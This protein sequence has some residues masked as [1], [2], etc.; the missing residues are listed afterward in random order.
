[1]CK[2][3]AMLTCLMCLTGLAF[4][5]QINVI[6]KPSQVKIAQGS[7]NFAGMAAIYYDDNCSGFVNV[8]GYLQTTLRDQL[9]RTVKIDK[10]DAS[11]IAGNAIVLK[12]SASQ[13]TLGSEGYELTVTTGRVTIL[14]NERV[15]VFYGVQTLLQLR[16]DETG[17][18]PCIE[19]TDSPRF[20]WRGLMLD[21][22]RTFQSVA[23]MKKTIDRMAMY[24]MNVLHL[25][26][27]DDQGWRV[28]IKK[29]PELTAKGARFP[30]K[31]EEPLRHQGYYTQ[32]QIKDLVQ[33]ATMRNI[34]VVPE[35]EMP[36]H[37]IAPLSCYPELSCSGGSFEIYPFFKG[38]GITADIFCAGNEATF[39]FFENVLDEVF[40]L[41]PSKFIHIG[42][43]EAPKSGWQACAKCQVR[44]KAEGLKDEHGLQSY[45]IKRVEKYANSKGKR[46]IG[47]D[48]ILEG[49]LAPNAAVMSWRGIGGGIAAASTGHD[50]VMSPTSHC[51]FDYTYKAIDTRKAYSFEPVP[52]QLSDEQAKHV[53]G[54]QANFW[55]HID[56]EEHLVD[57]Q[58]WPRL[59]AIAERG[60][61]AKS[62]R[63]WDDF[64]GRVQHNL[65][66]LEAF[67]IAYKPEV[68]KTVI[69]Q[70]KSG[71]VTEEYAPKIYDITKFLNKAG[72]CNVHFQYTGGAHRLG[73]EKVEML[74]DGKVIATDAHRG[75]TGAFD[76]ANEFLLEINELDEYKRY[77]I[78]AFVRSEGGID[79]NGEVSLI[80]KR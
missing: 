68:S 37:S 8:A 24:K 4:G 23:Y 44:I 58:L 16:D 33:Y 47:W 53:L 57:R 11:A 32:A 54:L 36:G 18:A 14:A 27:T 74:A 67:G 77:Q 26:L 46:I 62:V 15:G 72:T 1:M 41:F 40:E 13:P 51:Y 21:C 63:N 6:P 66:R 78:R 29:Y 80:K 70:W 28:E 75:V 5:Q 31:Y 12:C 59:L 79:S 34:T 30:E 22:S 76:Q 50:V 39:V 64:Q 55:S 73:I 65:N 7:F 52:D 17:Q 35:I 71:Q 20:Q 48:E 42:G 10:L 19:I 3:F 49:G 25:H 9:G 38:P 43:D 69:G 60:W 2:K 56:R 45:F 61:S